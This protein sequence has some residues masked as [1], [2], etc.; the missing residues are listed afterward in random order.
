MQRNVIPKEIREEILAK[1]RS[2]QRVAEL[3]K[4]YGIS[5]KSIYGWLHKDMGQAQKSVHWRETPDDIFRRM[6]KKEP[7]N[8][9]GQNASR[10]EVGDRELLRKIQMKARNHPVDIDVSIVQLG[11]SKNSISQDQLQLLSVTKNYL[12]QTYQLPLKV[13]IS[14]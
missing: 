10:F 12:M 3:A 13:I 6:Q 4:Q 9:G 7:K 14:P 1:A 2:G 8:N 5:D 11:V